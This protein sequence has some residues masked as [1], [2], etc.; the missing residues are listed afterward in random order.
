[1]HDELLEASQGYVPPERMADVLSQ[2][3]ANQH[4]LRLVALRNL[5]AESL[6]QPVRSAADGGGRDEPERGPYV[7]PVEIELEGSYASLVGYL[8]TLESL[9]LRLRWREIDVVAKKYP[10]NHVR[11]EIATLSLSR[12]WISV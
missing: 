9:P 5:P 2:L 6:A 7:H 12:D 4:D 11:I 1:M 8:R 3:L 10:L